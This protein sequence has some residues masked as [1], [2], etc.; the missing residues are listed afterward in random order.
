MQWLTIKG[1]ILTA[2][3]VKSVFEY[4]LRRLIFSVNLDGKHK[5]MKVRIHVDAHVQALEKKTLLYA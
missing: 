3:S 1:D 5:K 4:S 2:A